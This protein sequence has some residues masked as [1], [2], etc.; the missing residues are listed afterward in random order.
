MCLKMRETE[1][2]ILPSS[3]ISIEALACGC[4]VANGYFVDN[5]IE[6]FMMYKQ[7]GYC[8]GLGDLREVHDTLFIEDLLSFESIH[9]LDF[10]LI[11]TRYI[12]LFKS[13]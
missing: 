10:S 5:Q 13:L 7:K 2:A 3:T 9:Q 1:Y 8:V 6:T 4:K 11:P 12:H